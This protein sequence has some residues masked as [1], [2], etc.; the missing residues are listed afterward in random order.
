MRIL[1]H[2]EHRH[3]LGL[4]PQ[5]I[6]QRG[7]RLRLLLFGSQE[8]GAVVVSRGDRQERGEQRNGFCVIETGLGEQRGQLRKLPFGAVAARAPGRTL[9]VMYE[10]V[11]RAIRRNRV[12]TDIA[13]GCTGIPRCARR[14]SRPGAT[15]RCRLRRERES[16]D[17]RRPG[18]AATPEQVFVLGLPVY[19]RRHVM[20][21][22]GV[23]AA[24]RLAGAQHAPDLDRRRQAFQLV[25][26]L[27]G[28]T[29]KV[30]RPGRGSPA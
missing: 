15:C 20:A 4:P 10:R 13:A 16:P 17:P 8:E 25:H 3:A 6:E 11:Q 14:G 29:R 26:A 23:E 1:E 27:V 2:Q 21:V 9:E 24:L 7:E 22:G 19:E 12:S 28:S 5:A 18:R 30:R